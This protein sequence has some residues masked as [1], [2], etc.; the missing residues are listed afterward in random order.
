MFDEDDY[1]AKA[2]DEPMPYQRTDKYTEMVEDRNR[3]RD[4]C[5]DIVTVLGNDPYYLRSC[6]DSWIKKMY[7]SDEEENGQKLA[8]DILNRLT[9]IKPHEWGDR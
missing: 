3:W 9:K 8:D 7:D 1:L 4:L 2:P 6:M 5:R